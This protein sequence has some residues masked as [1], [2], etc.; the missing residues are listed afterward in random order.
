M[1]SVWVPYHF[2]R[3]QKSFFLSNFSSCTYGW[4]R[5]ISLPSLN[6]CKSFLLFSCSQ[7]EHLIVLLLHIYDWQ[8]EYRGESDYLAQFDRLQELGKGKFG[9]VYKVILIESK[10]FAHFF[11]YG[12]SYENMQG[13]SMHQVSLIYSI[14]SANKRNSHFN[15]FLLVENLA[16]Y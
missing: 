11:L 8:S 13:L 6:V 7:Q 5:R 10:V 12:C 2:D 15:I 16:F 4:Q 1:L 9:T 14:E 3:L